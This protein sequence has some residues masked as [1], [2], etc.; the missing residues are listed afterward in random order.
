MPKS[1]LIMICIYFCLN[2]LWVGTVAFSLVNFHFEL[3]LF[4]MNLFLAF[5][6]EFFRYS[7]PF[8]IKRCFGFFLTLII[9]ISLKLLSFGPKWYSSSSSLLP[10][11]QIDT[12]LFWAYFFQKHVN[13]VYQVPGNICASWPWMGFQV[14]SNN[15]GKS[16][17]LSWMQ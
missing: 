7:T 4:L 8:G 6:Y 11:Y 10:F 5:P 2:I 12:M 1:I 17:S 16:S 13:L 14:F 15:L 3:L 9:K